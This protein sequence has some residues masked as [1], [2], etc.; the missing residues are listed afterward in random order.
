MVKKRRRPAKS[1]NA[2]RAKNKQPTT[3]PGK[4]LYLASIA[5]LRAEHLAKMVES[6][7]GHASTP[8]ELQEIQADLGE[9]QVRDKADAAHFK[10]RAA[11]PS[12]LPSDL[13]QRRPAASP[14]AWAGAA[15][16]EKRPR[17]SS[18]MG[19]ER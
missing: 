2:K 19:T 14:R 3:E 6:I 1:P 12:G 5:H 10:G 16:G 9:I 15:L 4:Q 7:N 11:Q 18:A 13:T 17:R 8:E